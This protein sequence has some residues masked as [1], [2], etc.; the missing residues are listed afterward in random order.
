MPSCI[1]YMEHP[2]VS[3][4]KRDFMIRL[5]P[6][7]QLC[8]KTPLSCASN[9]GLRRDCTLTLLMCNWQFR[10]LRASP[11]WAER[12]EPTLSVSSTSFEDQPSSVMCTWHPA[13]T[14][15]HVTAWQ[16]CYWMLC[17]LHMVADRLP[18]ERNI[19]LATCIKC[20]LGVLKWSLK[21]NLARK[22]G[23]FM[24]LL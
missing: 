4:C 12:V 1:C 23:S 6:N 19:S 8:T 21:W 2:D 14:C 20:R 17:C 11:E 16:P 18:W 3:K 5:C 24:T 9:S 13:A 22:L 10:I 7:V 15:N